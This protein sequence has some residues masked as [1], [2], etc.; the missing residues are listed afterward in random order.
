MRGVCPA[1]LQ[2]TS[3]SR[4]YGAGLVGMDRANRHKI[5]GHTKYV[6]HRKRLP[7]IEMR[8][9]D[10]V[11]DQAAIVLHDHRRVGRGDAGYAL[12]PKGAD[13][14]GEIWGKRKQRRVAP[15]HL[16][17]T[18]RPKIARETDSVL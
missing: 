13:P 6:T 12:K 14:F 15:P 9:R 11:Q 7:Q 8:K 3:A 10:D 1:E 2:I 16:A 4:L 5:G 18:C 17:R